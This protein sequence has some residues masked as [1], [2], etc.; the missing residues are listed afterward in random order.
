M[1]SN[2]TVQIPA[3]GAEKM[4]SGLHLIPQPSGGWR[5][6]GDLFLQ[7]RPGELA[8]LSATIARRGVN[9]ERFHYNRSENIHLVRIT[10]QVSSGRV[11]GA[12]ADDLRARGC[13]GPPPD[14]W[15]K[16]AKITELGGLL[17]VKVNLEDRPGTLAAFAA[18]L[19]E[20]RANVIYMSYDGEQAPGVAAMAMATE[21]P[22]EVSALLQDLNARDYH[23]HVEWQ[24]SDGNSIDDVIGLSLVERFLLKLKTVLPADRLR[25]LTELIQSSQELRETLLSFKREAGESDESMAASEVFTQILQLATAS[26][27]KTGR[28]FS[29]RLTGPLP[30]TEQVSLYMLTCPTGANSYLLRAGDELTLIDSSYGLYY[31]DVKAWLSG[32]GID[33]SRIR[34]AL[35]SHADADH[36]G[37]AAPLQEDFGVEVLMHPGSEEIFRRENR[38][39]GSDS[40]LMALNGYYTKLINRFTDLRPPRSIRPF[41]PA[42]GEAGGFRIIGEV[43]VGDMVLHVLESLGGHVPAQVFFFA[44]R[45]GLLFCGDYLID[46]RSLSDR[47]KSTLSIARFL[48]T[49]TNSDGRVFGREMRQLA[50]LM[51]KVNAELASDGKSARIFPGHG[52]FYSVAEADWITA[53]ILRQGRGSDPPPKG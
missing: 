26:I 46:I 35:I 41:P 50:D 45:E 25:A 36:A 40:R 44:R 49:S 38:A 28:N 20:H 21:S 22:E 37:W 3:Q 51:M 47:T 34:R 15:K 30:L 13:L 42:G 33:P 23:Y 4:P 29:L 7:D 48:M 24:G 1:S 17:R 6:S 52:D 9:I 2:P 8:E 11:A 10:T 53:D 32:H 43:P 18:V 39:H 27:S 12:L 5:L 31:R 14:G 16:E 19:K